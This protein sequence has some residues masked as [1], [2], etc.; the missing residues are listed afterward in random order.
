MH[1]AS[2][3]Q[4]HGTVRAGAAGDSQRTMAVARVANRALQRAL[5]GE[6]T[7]ARW[8]VQDGTGA[9]GSG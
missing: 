9:L 3:V 2:S 7:V 1:A 5:E 4:R 6:L 8:S